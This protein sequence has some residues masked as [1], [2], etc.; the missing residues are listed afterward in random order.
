MGYAYELILKGTAKDYTRG[1]EIAKE[2]ATIRFDG[3]QD[4]IRITYVDGKRAEIA[5]HLMFTLD[6]GDGT[7]IALPLDATTETTRAKI[8]TKTNMHNRR[9]EDI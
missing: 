9:I 7:T 1:I 3:I 8:A 5:P 6:N 4:G 2:I